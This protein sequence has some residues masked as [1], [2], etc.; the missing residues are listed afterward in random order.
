MDAELKTFDVH[1]SYKY[2]GTTVRR[3]TLHIIASDWGAAQA[4]V[5]QQLDDGGHGLDCEITLITQR[6]VLSRADVA[7][8]AR[9]LK[10]DNP[11]VEVYLGGEKLA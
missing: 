11:L 5:A 10:A 7:E 1:V 2:H 9:K 8:I 6:R 4:Q 3:E